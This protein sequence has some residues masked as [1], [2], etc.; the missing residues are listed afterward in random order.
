MRGEG[1]EE[2]AVAAPRTT[3]RPREKSRNDRVDE[4]DAWVVDLTTAEDPRVTWVVV[5][6]FKKFRAGRRP[7]NNRVCWGGRVGEGPGDAPHAR[8]D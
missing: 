1:D 5:G 3:T 8:R 2:A 7:W 6:K 4:V